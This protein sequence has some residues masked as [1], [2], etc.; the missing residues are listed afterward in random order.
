MQFLMGMGL[1]GGAYVTD[2]NAMA[3]TSVIV[4]IGM[5]CWGVYDK[6]LTAKAMHATAV[7]SAELRT[8]LKANWRTTP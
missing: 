7:K 2:S 6:I 1:I 4:A 8:P 5:L 3:L